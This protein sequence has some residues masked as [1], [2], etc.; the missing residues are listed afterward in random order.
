MSASDEP[1][2]TGMAVR[3]PR[4]IIENS[5][6][7]TATYQAIRLLQHQEIFRQENPN[8]TF[9]Y[10]AGTV[11]AIACTGTDA[12]TFLDLLEN[13]VKIAKK[14]HEKNNLVDLPPEGTA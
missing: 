7:S 14:V 12:E 2:T 1:E 10:M 4:Q 8:Q 3:I 11:I 9:V 5:V 6:L 13:I